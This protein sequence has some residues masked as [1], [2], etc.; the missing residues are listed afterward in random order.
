MLGVT[1]NELV[2]RLLGTKVGGI[3]L[4]IKLGL[5]LVT[6]VRTA[7]GEI[8]DFIVGRTLGIEDGLTL[9]EI[10]RLKLDLTLEAVDGVVVLGLNFIDGKI[11]GMEDALI[12]D[13]VDFNKLGVAVCEL[14]GLPLETVVGES[15]DEVLD[16]M[17]GRTLGLDVSLTV[18]MVVGIALRKVVGCAVGKLL[19]VMVG[20]AIGIVLGMIEFAKVGDPLGDNVGMVLGAVVGYETG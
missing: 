20:V 3:V 13:E 16:F 15:E 2:G 19:G 6:V 4:L 14:R 10:V 12:V 5:T 7:D 18:G 1:D 9:G 11:L 17:V 8:V